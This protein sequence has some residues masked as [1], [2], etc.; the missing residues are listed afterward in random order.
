[1]RWSTA[2]SGAGGFVVFS[3]GFW[4]VARCFLAV[5]MVFLCDLA[6]QKSVSRWCWMNTLPLQIVGSKNARPDHHVDAAW[7]DLA[8][9][10]PLVR[11]FSDPSKRFQPSLPASRTPQVGYQTP[12]ANPQSPILFSPLFLSLPNHSPNPISHPPPTPDGNTRQ[13]DQRPR[14]IH[15]DDAPDPQRTDG[16]SAFHDGVVAAHVGDV[17]EVGA[18]EEGE[19]EEE[20]L[21]DSLE[22]GG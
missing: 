22:E 2:S 18:G 5:R 3:M 13:T 20:G 19:G 11:N 14:Q 7:R 16:R 12:Q 17:E 10:S 15:L 21:V 9:P 1:M 8:I 6:S 4:R